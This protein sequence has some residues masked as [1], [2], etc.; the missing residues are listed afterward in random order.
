MNICWGT[1]P[2]WNINRAIQPEQYISPQISRVSGTEELRSNGYFMWEKCY[3]AAFHCRELWSWVAAGEVGA[4][5]VF[6]GLSCVSLKVTP[7]P[8]TLVGTASCIRDTG[9]VNIPEKGPSRT[10]ILCGTPV[11]LANAASLPAGGKTGKKTVKN[12]NVQAWLNL[13]PVLIWC[14]HG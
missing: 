9:R 6:M 12:E 4:K 11:P 1:E 14:S 2:Q 3:R 13:R 8:S 5:P 10:S 7:E